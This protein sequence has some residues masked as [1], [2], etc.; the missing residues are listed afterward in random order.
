[1]KT[2]FS[3]VL[4]CMLAGIMLSSA[5]NFSSAQEIPADSKEAAAEKADSYSYPALTS[6]V[7]FSLIASEIA[8]QRHQ[9]G[10]AFLTLMEEAKKTGNP[11]IARRAFAIANLSAAPKEASEALALWSKLTAGTPEAE[12]PAAYEALRSGNFDA[13]EPAFAKYLKTQSRPSVV[14]Q[15]IFASLNGQ[16]IDKA[17]PLLTSLA[18]PYEAS[19]P[20]VD[21]AICSVAVQGAR[22]DIAERFARSAIKAA[23]QNPAV[24]R[25]AAIALMPLEPQASADMLKQFLKDSPEDS[26]TRLIYAQSLLAGKQKAEFTAQAKLLTTKKLTGTQWIQ[27]GEMAEQNGEPKIAE[28]AYST[29]LK[30]EQKAPADERNL[31]Y[32]R[33]GFLSENQLRPEDALSWYEQVTDGKY[34][35]AARLR[36]ADIYQKTGRPDRAIAVLEQ[37]KPKADE[38]KIAITTALSQLL[39]AANQPWQAYDAMQQTAKTVGNAPDFLYSTAMQ[40]DKV[41]DLQGVEFYLRKYI[42]LRPNSSTGYNALGY[43]FAERNVQLREALR[44]VE[45][46]NTLKPRDPYILDS[47]GWVYYRLKNYEKAKQFLESSLSLRYDA[48]TVE[49]LLTVLTQAGDRAAAQAELDKWAAQHPDD[50]SLPTFRKK[51]GLK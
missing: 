7:L 5:P 32:I 1:M 6:D 50:Q 18:K 37:A 9:S 29:F 4:P 25:Q 22:R 34:Y 10:S 19:E 49:H 14:F 15:Q 21:L 48:E 44:L 36:S 28:T 27:L 13:A 51:F 30:T 40:A 23:P 33:L 20:A 26:A 45:K 11:G 2:A 16:R 35:V 39:N 12:V 41:N 47:L 31:A 17:L 42:A 43:I 24:I 3:H 8:V 38:G 46:A